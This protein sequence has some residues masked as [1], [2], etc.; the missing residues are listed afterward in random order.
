[1]K[2]QLITP[3]KMIEKLGLEPKIQVRFFKNGVGGSWEL[4]IIGKRF[5]LRIARHQIAFWDGYNPIF[6]YSL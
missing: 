1:M 2:S 6:N 4:N 5:N 3:E